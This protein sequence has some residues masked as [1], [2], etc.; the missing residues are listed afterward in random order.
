MRCNALINTILQYLV[1]S[2]PVTRKK[3]CGQP[4]SQLFFYRLIFVEVPAG[5][6]AS[7]PARNVVIE[8]IE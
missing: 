4:V 2:M 3:V 7:E 5:E 1:K 6:R 8:V